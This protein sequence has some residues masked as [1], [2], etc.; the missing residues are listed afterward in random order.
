MD[1]ELGVRLNQNLRNNLKRFIEKVLPG[2]MLAALTTRRMMR[3]YRA[4][5]GRSTKDV[6][7][8][9]HDSNH[10]RGRQSV[11]GQGSD[12][13][14]TQ[15]IRQTLPEII[16]RFGIASI[17]D[18]PCGDFNWMQHVE[19]GDCTY[20]GGDIV[21]AAAAKC[22][23]A[24][25]NATRRF[26]QIDITR[27]ELPRVDLI[28]C[29]DCFIHLPREL[30]Q[31]ALANFKRSGARYLFVTNAPTKT[32]NVDIPPGGYRPVNFRLAPYH[33]PPPLFSMREDPPSRLLADNP[34]Y[35]RYMELWELSSIP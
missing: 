1:S 14:Q 6:F 24:F 11:S 2:K 20:T 18:V 34:D 25:G 27:D 33:F 32:F 10:W 7:T 21:A 26:I 12:F 16:E 4:F 13:E 3:R 8:E 23:A 9:I 31:K 35:Q 15:T 30:I 22:Q 28:I 29:R 19:L 17:L 5:A